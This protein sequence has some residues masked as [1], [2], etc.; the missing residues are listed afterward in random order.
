MAVIAVGDFDPAVVEARIRARFAPIPRATTARPR[1]PHTVPQ[2]SSPAFVIATDPEQTTTQVN[3]GTIVPA[4]DESTIGSY[5]SHIVETLFSSMLSARFSEMAQQPDA[6]FL[7]AGAGRTSFVRTAEMLSLVAAVKEDGVER[8]LEALFV[9]AERVTRFGFTATELERQKRRVARS[10][11]QAVAE[12]DNQQ[13]ADLA[14]E[15]SRN[16]LEGEPIPGIVYEH[17][18]Y[19]RFLPG[20]A[21]E[22]VNALART[23]SPDASRIVLVTAPEKAGLIMPTEARLS[24][25]I[26]GAGAKATTAY[27]DGAASGALLSTPPAPGTVASTKT[28]ESIGITEWTLSNGVRVVLKPTIIQAGRS[29]VPRLQPGRFVAGAGR[30]LR[31]GQHRRAGDR[32]WRRG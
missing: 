25:V 5:R 21:V 18:L 30:A 10:L 1:A 7:G 31:V 24:A 26:A 3:V 9:E 8:G 12:K 2:R 29:A 20:I 15:Y 23:W 27:D 32:G 22:E 19:D 11:E 16:Y 13:S 4:R 14:A 28:I 17:A 6:P